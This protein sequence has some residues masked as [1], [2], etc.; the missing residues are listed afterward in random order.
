M[1]RCSSSGLICASYSSRPPPSC[2]QL[3]ISV[4]SIVASGRAVSLRLQRCVIRR[5]IGDVLIAE[6]ACKCLHHRVVALA[7]LVLVHRLNERL[8][9]LAGQ[10]RAGLLALTVGDRKST[11]LN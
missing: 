2:T 9:A 8:L 6:L 11:R 10:R 3:T 7:G 4:L 5:H 1:Q